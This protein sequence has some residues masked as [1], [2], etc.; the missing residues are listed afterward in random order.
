VG[1]GA[2]PEAA[3]LCE[4]HGLEYV[5]YIDVNRATYPDKLRDA[6]ATKPAR[7]NVQLGN[8]DTAPKEAADL[9]AKLETQARDM[10]L[11]VDL[12]VHRDTA[13]ETPEKVYEIAR[14]FEKTTGKKIRFCWDFSHLAVVKH[15][16]PPFANRLLVAPDLV[17]LARQM[18]FRP[19]NGHHAQIPATD[20]KGNDTAEFTNYLEFVDA[21]LACWFKA[22]KGGEILY[23]CPEF[24]PT[25]SGYGLSSFPNVWK[26]AILLR[27]K[28]EALW[29]AHVR[30]WR[31]K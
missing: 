5:C 12:E 8:H 3:A 29:Q 18:H 13:T 19:F 31:R 15:L 27:G 21:L 1:G 20:G 14:L 28:T 25:E 26:D 16:H 30:R 2:M 23:A 10:G 22:A 6:L 17:Q 9:W 7:V 11:A 24:G 4:A